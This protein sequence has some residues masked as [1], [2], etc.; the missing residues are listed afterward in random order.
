MGKSAVDETLPNYGGVY[1]GNGSHTQ[2]REMVESSDLVLS[3]GAIKSDFNTSGF[4][5]HTSQLS[6]VDFHSR[7]V[8]VKYAEYRNCRMN[9]VLRKVAQNLDLSRLSVQPVPS[10]SGKFSSTADN[11][12]GQ[13]VTHG[14]FWPTFSQWVRENDIII[15]ETGTAGYVSPFETRVY[16]CKI[17][18][19]QGIWEVNFKK[20]VQAI[21][22]ILWGSIGYATG[23]CQGA[24]L[25]AKETGRN[26]TILFTGDGSFQLTAQEL[27]K[28]RLVIMRG[29]Y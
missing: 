16:P 4:T 13:E 25:A 3:I 6:A 23:S 9:G 8:K 18:M 22:Q 10:D 7:V 20:G 27:S 12:N 5:Y 17:D 26:R 28:C 24:A 21:S 14:W 1:A 15:T 2:V 29:S 19:T 11:V